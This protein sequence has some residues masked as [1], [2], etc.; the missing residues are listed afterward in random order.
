MRTLNKWTCSFVAVLFTALGW[1]QPANDACTSAILLTAGTSCSTTGTTQNGS[2]TGEPTACNSN[3]TQTVWYYFQAT[4][5]SMDIQLQ[6]TGLLGGGSGYF[7]DRWGMAVYN[8]G[9]NSTPAA[10]CPTITNAS[11][12]SGSCINTNTVGSGDGVMVAYL[13]GLTLNNYY[14]IQVGYRTGNGSQIPQFCINRFNPANA[15][16]HDCSSCSSP[17]GASCGFGS[18][19]CS[20]SG[21]TTAQINAI[22]ASCTQ[23]SAAPA[24][25]GGT[26]A[27]QCWTFT[28]E[29]TSG[30]IN[31]IIYS[32]C[33]GGNV[34]NF[35]WSLQTSAC[36]STVASGDLTDMT[37]FDNYTLTIGQSYTYCLSFTVP[38]TCAHFSY[39]PFVWG[40]V[41][42]PIELTSFTASAD[43]GG[44][45][46]SW[47]T[48]SE[49]NNDYFS[50]QH[51]N[52]GVSYQEIARVKGIGNSQTPT[53]YE[54]IDLNALPG[55]NFYRL[56]QY[57]FDGTYHY[58]QVVEVTI[59]ITELTVTLSPNLIANASSQLTVITET[60]GLATIIISNSLGQVVD[61]ITAPVRP[62][63]NI[64][65]LNTESYRTG[66]Y[67]L[68]VAVRDES[69]SL[70]F[71]K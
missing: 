38:T 6:L 67:H 45:Q 41:T 27:S 47:T 58:S 1:A 46:L 66:I 55:T 21:C 39:Y 52:T 60:T 15:T 71:I 31:E 30:G 68:S 25:E 29:G 34:S 8:A 63:N 70:K 2:V 14:Y 4:S 49:V 36:G 51:S 33:S 18:N 24:F 35:S 48:D 17:C 12:V 56:V 57:D 20:S 13:T 37:T 64:V 53:G 65:T 69:A 61:A 40:A 19:P 50:I 11:M 43:E 59:P 28:A 54:Y 32:N 3:W 22:T 10:A 62:G 42:L 7:P 44:V 16:M 23:F 5:T 9:T 26:N